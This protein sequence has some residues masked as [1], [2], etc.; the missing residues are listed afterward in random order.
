M[1]LTSFCGTP[2]GLAYLLLL[3]LLLRSVDPKTACLRET[4][5]CVTIDPNLVAP[6]W[7]TNLW[8]PLQRR[9]PEV[10]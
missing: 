5:C 3:L 4:R 7:L 1:D 6:K 2:L 10:T 9:S 8:I